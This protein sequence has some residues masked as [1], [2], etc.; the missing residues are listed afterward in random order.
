MNKLSFQA[1]VPLKPFSSQKPY[2]LGQ[3][4]LRNTGKKF[5]KIRLEIKIEKIGC[6]YYFDCLI[7]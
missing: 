6:W 5:D 2:E 7:S 3:I 1:L 4:C